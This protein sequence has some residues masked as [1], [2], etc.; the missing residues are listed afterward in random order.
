[1][2]SDKVKNIAKV[3]SARVKKPLASQREI[4]RDIWLDD[5]TVSNLE[6]E[7]PQISAKSEHIE[8]IIAK[9]LQIV[10]LA[11]QILQDRLEAKPDDISTRDIIASADVSAKRYSL[12]KWDATDKEW[13]MKDVT[14]ILSE[15]Q[16]LKQNN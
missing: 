15:I 13:G 4:A 2:R 5:K 16:W 14:S 11:Q 12:F 1:M 10:N 8:A 9:D 3:A 6:K 7:L